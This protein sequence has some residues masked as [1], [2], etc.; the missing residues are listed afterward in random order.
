MKLTGEQFVPHEARG[1]ISLQLTKV[2]SWNQNPEELFGPQ[3]ESKR[4]LTAFEYL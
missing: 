3:P 1:L 2:V 4:D